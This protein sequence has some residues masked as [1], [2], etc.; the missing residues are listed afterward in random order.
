MKRT[1]DEDFYVDDDPIEKVIAAFDKG[2]K[3]V[4]AKPEMTLE[5]AHEFYKNLDNLAIVGPGQR[6]P[7]HKKKIRQDT[8]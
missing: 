7:W 6:P 3:G 8:E 4:T 1:E 2:Q 5:E